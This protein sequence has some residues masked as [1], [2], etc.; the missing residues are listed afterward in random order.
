LFFIGINDW[1]FSQEVL[2]EWQEDKYYFDPAVSFNGA[3]KE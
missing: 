3:L 2:D 1:R